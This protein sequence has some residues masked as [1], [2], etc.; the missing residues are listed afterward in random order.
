MILELNPTTVHPCRPRPNDRSVNRDDGLFEKSRPFLF[1][2]DVLAQMGDTHNARRICEIA[3]RR[4]PQNKI[5]RRV[6]DQLALGSD[7]IET[8]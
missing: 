1:L 7:L 6:H 2:C 3:L 8:E 4:D 5:A